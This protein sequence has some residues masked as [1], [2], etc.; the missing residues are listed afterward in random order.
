V[1]YFFYPKDF[2]FVC[3]TELAEFNKQLK[4]FADRD[5]KVVGGSTAFSAVDDSASITINPVN[6]APQI[7][8]TGSDTDASTLSEANAGLSASGTLT[9]SDVDGNNTVSATVQSLVT[10]GVTSGLGSNNATLLGMLS[11]SPSTVLS[12]PATAASLT[13]AFNSGSE[14]FN[15]LATGEQLTLTYTIKATDSAATPLSTTT[16][17]TITVIGSNDGPTITVASGNS[18]AATLAETNAGLT[19]SGSLTVGDLDRTDT[20]TASVV[21]VVPSGSTTGPSGALGSSNSQ[22]LAMLSVSPSNILSNTFV[23]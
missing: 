6:D 18:D 8:K 7:N 20:A 5:T 3:P 23:F 15:H 9:V 10:A 12:T 19:S 13:W 1:V 2:T 17:V 14:A 11:L 16:T 22:L 4:N 21:S